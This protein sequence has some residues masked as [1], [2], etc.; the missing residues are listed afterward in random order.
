ME[1]FIPLCSSLYSSDEDFS[2]LNQSFHGT[3]RGTVVTAMLQEKNGEI[4]YIVSINNAKYGGNMDVQCIAAQRFG[5]IFN[6]EDSIMQGFNATGASIAGTG[7]NIKAGDHVLVTF[8][9]GA[10]QQGVIIGSLRHMGRKPLLDQA[11]GPQLFSTF[12]GVE[13]SVNADGEFTIRYNGI[14]TN[15]KDLDKEPG[16]ELPEAVYDEKFGSRIFFSKDGS[17]TIS[18]SK[19]DDEDNQMMVFDNENK[20]I[21]IHGGKNITIKMDRDSGEYTN[22]SKKIF[23][24][25]SEEEL[26]LASFKSTI[27]VRS[28]KEATLK[29][30]KQ[31][32]GEGTHPVSYGDILK[33]ALD[34][35]FDTLNNA[36]I[37]G[38]PPQNAT[39]LVAVKTAAVAA[40][41]AISQ[42]NSKKTFTD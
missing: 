2:A 33:T 30:S 27:T 16:D 19:A 22:T 3:Y 10:N 9:D 36:I 24:T 37:P 21:L 12:N 34:T 28:E 25:S 35:F 11:S 6:Y 40:K 29:G 5:G 8:I 17:I 42:M 32:L 20:K 14:P 4:H 38:S 26:E 15:I 39:S 31:L 23:I 7:F 13:R 41:Q 18:D 1:D